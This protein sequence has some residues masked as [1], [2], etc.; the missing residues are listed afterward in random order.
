MGESSRLVGHGYLF[1]GAQ[2]VATIEYRIT[3]YEPPSR[4][5]FVGDGPRFHGVDEITFEP[6]P[7][8]GTR[9]RYIADLSLKGA[10]R[11]VE[12][13]MHGKFRDMGAHAE[14][15]PIGSL[16]ATSATHSVC[17]IQRIVGSTPGAGAAISI[18]RS[19]AAQPTKRRH[20]KRVNFRSTF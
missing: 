16:I 15:I 19:A 9:V 3:A 11:L 5:V 4:V 6:W 8:G 13:F 20:R 7:A 10:G 18:S 2:R 14:P 12:P 17:R 1:N